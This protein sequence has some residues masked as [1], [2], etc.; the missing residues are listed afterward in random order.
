MIQADTATTTPAFDGTDEQVELAKRL[1]PVFQARGRFFSDL[2]PIRLT[3][4]QLAE[5]LDQQEPGKDWVPLIDAA[6]SASPAVFSREEGNDILS[7]ATTRAGTAVVDGKDGTRQQVL[8]R[9]FIEPEPRREPARPAARRRTPVSAMLEPVVEEPR[10]TEPYSTI[11]T[12]G[13]PEP[14]ITQETTPVVDTQTEVEEEVTGAAPD[15]AAAPASP[16]TAAE[17]SSVDA[18][19][20][21]SASNE[22]LVEAVRS[23]L[24]RELAVAHWG[25]FWMAEDR[26]ERLSRGDLR[27]IEDYLRE[28]DSSTASDEDIVQDVLGVRPNAPEYGT[29]RF[30]VNYRLSRETREFEYLGTSRQGLWSIANP[31]QLGTSKRKASEIGQDYRF[32]LDYRTPDEAIEE[33]LVEHIL[34]F[35]EYTYG[36]LPLD[37]NIAS[38][39]PTAGFPDQ[40]AARITFES[41][42]TNETFPAELRF[43]TGNRGGFIAGLDTFFAENLIPGAVVTIERTERDDQFLL[44]YFRVSGEDRKL[45]QVDEK[46]GKFAFRSTTYYCA[47]QD[48]WILSENRYPKL[49][50]AK[51]LDDRARRRPE[52]VVAV[53]FE[54][55]GENVGDSLIPRFWASFTDLLAV[56]N[57]ERPISAELLRDILTSGTYQEF[58]VDDSTEDAFFYSPAETDE[59]ES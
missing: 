55:V 36:V 42:Q 1:F 34:S 56:A 50:D 24:G 23:T 43:P 39:M 17:S 59:P 2:T 41:P 26:V 51:P 35:Y 40:R 8:I 5:F 32:L 18:V 57:V 48:E 54:R 29:R 4:D 27:R 46:K 30:A 13:M 37:A 6:L 47:T 19:D 44:E 25:D 12:L 45:L 3:V 9:R 53:T 49:T 16:P 31:T 33:G 52:Q 58:S 22:E 7:F 10:R 11:E 20:T 38:I 28:Q 15:V 21:A 14:D